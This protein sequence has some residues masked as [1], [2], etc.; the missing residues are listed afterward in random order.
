MPVDTKLLEILVC[1]VDKA[2]LN[3]VDL[4][5]SVQRNLVERYRE[6]F[7]D[8]EPEVQQALE[9]TQCGRTYPIVSEIPVMLEDH[10]L[11]REEVTG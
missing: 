10:A 6:E 9:C 2:E 1:P 4:S 11:A 5:K 3:L 7:K 8:E